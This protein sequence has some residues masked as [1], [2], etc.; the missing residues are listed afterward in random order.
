M[1]NDFNYES[2]SRNV[3]FDKDYYNNPNYISKPLTNKEEKSPINKLQQNVNWIFANNSTRKTTNEN[4]EEVDVDGNINNKIL[5]KS[6]NIEEKDFIQ[7]NYKEKTKENDYNDLVKFLKDMINKEHVNL[8]INNIRSIISLLFNKA[9]NE[10]SLSD[11]YN[12]LKEIVNSLLSLQEIID[13]KEIIDKKLIKKT[14]YIEDFSPFANISNNKEENMNKILLNT[15]SNLINIPKCSNHEN[16]KDISFLS[17]KRILPKIN[18]DNEKNN[19]KKE[20]ILITNKNKK[21][22]I[23]IIKEDKNTL[24]PK[25]GRIPNKKKEQN[26]VG[27]HD[28]NKEDNG[29]NKIFHKSLESIYDYSLKLIKEI[30]E[31]CRIFKPVINKDSIKNNTE[32]EKYIFRTIKENI[33]YFKSGNSNEENFENNRLKIEAI[34]NTI[35]KGKEKE[36]KILNNLWNMIYLGGLRMYLYDE[37]FMLFEINGKENLI[38]L[39]GFRTFKD[40]F[41]EYDKTIQDNFIK[42]AEELI[43]GEASKRKSRT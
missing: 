4:I 22:S 18:S 10:K 42:K 38:Y 33:C 24:K 6:N 40:D 28:R 15:N 37:P 31:N 17:K 43:N 9:R 32:K 41:S 20:N 19:I 29:L 1:S 21:D 5:N 12:I 8:K 2:I 34:L 7:L 35:V 11:I 13:Q 23:T 30:D 14:E 16:P 26:V 27:T 3:P 25:R 36:I 39:S